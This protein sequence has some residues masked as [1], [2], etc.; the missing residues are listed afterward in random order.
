MPSETVIFFQSSNALPAREKIAGAY[1]Y[2]ESTNWGVQLVEQNPSPRDIRKALAKWQP[3]G[4]VVERGLT[5]GKSPVRLFARTPVVYIDQNPE[6]AD[7]GCWHVQSDARALVRM[8]FA[9]LARTAPSHYAFVRSH[10]NRSWCVARE[11]EFL[12]LVRQAKAA[13]TLLADDLELPENLADLPRPCGVLAVNDSIAQKVVDA[14]RRE[15]I[16]MP[17]D[18]RIVGINNDEF[19]CTHTN[20]TLTSVQPDFEGC[21]FLALSVL[22]RL[23]KGTSA[24]PQTV[25]FGPTALVRRDSTRIFARKDPRVVRALDFIA[26]HYADSSLKTET[27][28]A[29]MGCSRGLADLRFKEVTGHTIRTELRQVRLAAAK[30]LLA[31]PT[32]ELS[33]IPSLCG[34]Q[35]IPT[36]ANFFKR[37]T[38]KTMSAW[39]ESK[40]F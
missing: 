27:I 1:R 11:R 5:T 13:C 19:I 14:A 38:G 24:R 16:D 9:E 26:A 6:N 34:Y 35:S 18:M 17:N 36:F 10:K 3:V 40:R 4:C 15:R 28:A 37:E 21:G 31:D 33:A 30:R 23:V 22:H 8:A 32:R 20:P 29:A 12:R 25:F 7:T 39:R 2:L